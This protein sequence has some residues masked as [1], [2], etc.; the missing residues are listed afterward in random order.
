[1]QEKQA[2]PRQLATPSFVTFAAFGSF[3][4]AWGASVPRVQDQAGVTD[5]Q[6]GLALLFVGAGALPAML[7]AGKA[8]DRWGLKVAALAITALGAVGTGL[9]LTAVSLPS[10]SVGLAPAG[11]ASGA[12]DVAM[13]AVAGRAESIAKR[14]VITRAHGIFSAAVV[15]ASLTTGLASAASLPL[16][17][18]FITVAVLCL[19]AGIHLVKTLPPGPVPQRQDPRATSQHAQSA[20][21]TLRTRSRNRLRPQPAS[22]GCRHR[23][24][25]QIARQPQ[26]LP[27]GDDRK[28]RVHR[29]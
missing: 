28:R 13:N 29:C 11:S 14:P 5:G 22:P 6:L 25:P 15:L 10:L 16:V 1:M 27:S 20:A 12:A 4:G 18:P 2:S 7:L 3:W 21:S 19:A 23:A 26:P 9:A 24:D 17:V 8:L